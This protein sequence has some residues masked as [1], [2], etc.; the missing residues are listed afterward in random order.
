MYKWIVLQNDEIVNSGILDEPVDVF[1]EDIFPK[2]SSSSVD[3]YLSEMQE[4]ADK[5]LSEH[6]YIFRYAEVEIDFSDLM[7]E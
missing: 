7:E 2:V 3:R 6:K 5:Y 4:Y 1:V